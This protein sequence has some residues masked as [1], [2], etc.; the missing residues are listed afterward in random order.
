MHY[1]L[2]YFAH[3]LAF[4]AYVPYLPLYLQRHLGLT[5]AHIGWVLAIS[6]VVGLAGP[7]AWGP[8]V[9]H[10]SRRR[11]IL[12]VGFVGSA[13]LFP[14]YLLAD[15]LAEVVF[16][17]VLFG[18]MFAPLIPLLDDFLL[19]RIRTD[20][21]DY[22]RVRLWGSL[23]FIVG[24]TCVGWMLD[25]GTHWSM[26]AVF[27]AAEVASLVVILTFA[28]RKINYRA[29]TH[30]DLHFWRALSGPFV[31]FL[32]SAFVGRVSTVGHYN[33]YSLYLDSIGADD[34][35]KGV[36][37]SLGVVA[38]IV[39]ML[40]AGQV[41]RRFGAHRLFLWGLLGSAARFMLY[42]A[43][44]TVAGAMVGQLFHA[45]SF[46][47]YHIGAVTLVSELSPPGRTGTGQ[48]ALASLAYG[49]GTTVGSLLSGQAA[50]AW[51][52]RIM[53]VASSGL[54]I[55]AALI[56]VPFIRQAQAGGSRLHTP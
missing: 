43:W 28:D 15:S 52:Y 31:V 16:L 17:T 53:Y 10:T 6:G 39:M 13:A 2:L 47:A 33:F 7:F 24:S 54:A 36:A 50:D 37:W 3:F 26:F 30:K 8:L 38:E 5:Q 1:A 9:D 18:A 40:I 32:I 27:V 25:R 48:L 20:G 14:L 4:G 21:G 51:G 22:G 23:A 49:L 55:L 45:F 34:A 12:G 29:A 19:Y 41:V 56:A 44:P 35:L 42:A 46:G 11:L